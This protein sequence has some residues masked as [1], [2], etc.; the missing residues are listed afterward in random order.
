MITVNSNIKEA[1][2]KMRQYTKTHRK[3]AANTLHTLA[4]KHALPGVKK[5]AQKDLDRP[6][7]FTLRSFR[8]QPKHFLKGEHLEKGGRITI[9]KRAANYL[10]HNMYGGTRKAKSDWIVVPVT[11][12]ILDKYGNIKRGLRPSL[13]K[14]KYVRSHG[15]RNGRK[16]NRRR[17][18]IRDKGK[19]QQIWSVPAKGAKSR[20]WQLIALRYPT[21]KKER[22]FRFHERIEGEINGNFKRVAEREYSKEMKR[23]F[24]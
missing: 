15:I 23:V 4:K 21:Q 5:Q 1:H 14:R 13:T 9:G 18:Y 6:K 17:L 24:G 8:V 3:I 11:R 12:T 22:I 16:D 7:P 2:L 10:A 19:V 20:K